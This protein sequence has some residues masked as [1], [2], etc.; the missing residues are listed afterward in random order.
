[1]KA[2]IFHGSTPHATADKFW[3]SWLAQQLNARSIKAKVI[4]LPRLS[5]Q[6]LE[7]TLD[8]IRLMNLVIDSETIFIGH[9]AGANLLLTLL[10]NVKTP[11]SKSLFIAGFSKP[12]TTKEPTLKEIYAFERIKANCKDFIFVNSFN[13]PFGCGFEQGKALFDQLGGTMLAD[14]GKHYT[15]K[16]YPLFLKLVL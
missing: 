11:I 10:E 12:T 9:S 8:E 5:R 3:Y 16:E 7:E 15:K 14:N 6:T 4:D 1:M 2:Y 13:D